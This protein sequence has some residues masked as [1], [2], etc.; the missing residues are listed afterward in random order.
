M[1]F[2]NVS[3]PQWANA[4]HMAIDCLVTFD[5]IGE[6]VQF[7]ANPNDSEEHGRDIFAL[8]EAG[9]FGPVADYVPPPEPVK[10]ADAIAT[11]EGEAAA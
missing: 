8:C 1:Q 2:S 5:H 9:A 7:T 4:E 11:S 10:A 6:P 3:N